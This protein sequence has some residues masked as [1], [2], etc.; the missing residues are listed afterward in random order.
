MHLHKIALGALTG[1]MI[2]FGGA[3]QAATCTTGD[4]SLTIGLTSY[5]PTSCNA[6]TMPNG[7]NGF[8][9]AA[10]FNGVFGTSLTYLD[11]SDDVGSTGDALS[12]IRFTVDADEDQ[13]SGNWSI[14]WEDTNG[15]APANLPITID[16][17]IFLKGGTR[18]GDGYLFKDVLIP[19]S[20]TSGSGTFTVRFLNNGGQI[21]ELSHLTAMGTIVGRP[22]IPV[23]E[24]G[25][26]ALLGAGLLGL[27]AA[28]RR[29]RRVA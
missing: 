1:A 15:A 8:D 3:A 17:G 7:A 28:V 4:V 26:L 16:L 14:R 10:T 23:P 29:R 20:P 18:T 11:K 25:S 27:G 13:T 2:A 12:G 24:P 19:E 6:V 5:T 21:G 9:E 22:D